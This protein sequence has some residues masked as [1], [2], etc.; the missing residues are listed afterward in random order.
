MQAVAPLGSDGGVGVKIGNV[1]GD[2]FEGRSKYHRETQERAM[3]IKIGKRLARCDASGHARDAV[4]EALQWR[5][6]S[7]D[8]LP[9]AL[10]DQGDVPGKLNHVAEALLG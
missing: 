9:A 8:H 2:G 5:M 6:T 10:A 4:H 7:D 1:R 3:D